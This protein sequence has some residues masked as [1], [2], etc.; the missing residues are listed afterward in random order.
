M[1]SLGDY[2]INV[3]TLSLLPDKV[4]PLPPCQAGAA[5]AMECPTRASSVLQAAAPTK[6]LAP[7]P[8]F[9]GLKLKLDYITVI[10]WVL[11]QASVSPTV[12]RT[13]SAT[14]LFAKPGHV[15]GKHGDHPGAYLTAACTP[16]CAQRVAPLRWC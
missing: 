16:L 10:R 12:A 14:A 15:Q 13:A 8:L 2:G 3:D 1:G 7:L 11:G 9:G 5:R 6:S 4:G